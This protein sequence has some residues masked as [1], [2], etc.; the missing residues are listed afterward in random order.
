M[1]AREIMTAGGASA[2]GYRVGERRKVFSLRP[3]SDVASLND[4][5]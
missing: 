2:A 3:K 4:W 1:K 5:P